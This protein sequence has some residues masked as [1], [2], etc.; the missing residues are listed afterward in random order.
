MQSLP[1][2]YRAVVVGA[3]GTIGSALARQLQADARCGQLIALSRSSKPSVNFQ[4]EKSIVQAADY[5]RDQGPLHLIIV[6]TG[7]LHTPDG[8]PEKRL[9]QINY[10]QLMNSFTINT[11]GPAMVCAHFSPLLAR[12]E[13]SLLAVLSAKVGSI[14]D[15]YLGGWYSYRA[16]KAALNM[17][18][19]TASIELART[20]PHAVL[21]ALHPGTVDSPLSAPFR[22]PHTKRTATQAAAELLQVIDG[23]PAEKTCHF[24]AYDGQPLPW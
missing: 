21:A 10:H 6:A 18:V 17:I 8:W 15:N 22:S 23:L 14:Q 16:S 13:R 4:D 2:G 11:F 20:H 9:S 1:D 7:M 24:W 12:H 5:L 3:T 19:K